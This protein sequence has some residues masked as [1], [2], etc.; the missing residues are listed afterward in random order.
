ML[1]RD[2]WKAKTESVQS[3]MFEIVASNEINDKYVTY[4]K[5]RKDENNNKQKN[6]QEEKH[7]I[8]NNISEINTERHL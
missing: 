8:H 2:E 6:E 1:Q 7:V 3:P 4:E 5:V